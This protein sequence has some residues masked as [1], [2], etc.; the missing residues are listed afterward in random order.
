MRRILV[1]AALS[2]VLAA[3]GSDGSAPS[4]EGTSP[5]TAADTTNASTVA[6]GGESRSRS[7]SDGL[8]AAPGFT[9]ELGQGGTF[10][11]AEE[12]RP[13]FMIFWAEW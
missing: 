1:F 12:R 10:V 13:V 2:L 4:D 11:L 8:G 6:P 7:D 3:C 5:P 9:L